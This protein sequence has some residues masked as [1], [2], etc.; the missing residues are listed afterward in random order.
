MTY[1]AA[2][3]QVTQIKEVKVVYIQLNNE[4]GNFDILDF[5]KERVTEKAVKKSNLF[6]L[7]MKVTAKLQNI[8]GEK[9]I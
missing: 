2:P 6:S 4:K 3:R 1:T 9:F 7:K 8:S 5:G